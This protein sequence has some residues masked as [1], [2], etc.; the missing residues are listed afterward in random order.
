[1]YLFGF[2]FVALAFCLAGSQAP[3]ML[4]IHIITGLELGFWIW[5]ELS[6]VLLCGSWWH[7]KINFFP[8]SYLFDAY[9]MVLI[10]NLC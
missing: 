2:G 10:K 6:L 4:D 9:K 7:L 3:L 8:P 5:K 1:M